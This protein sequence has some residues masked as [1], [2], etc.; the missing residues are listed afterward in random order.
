MGDQIMK[1]FS[2]KNLAMTGALSFAGFGLVGVGAHAVFT[3]STSSQQQIT[4][5]TMNVVLSSSGASGN[6]TAN[7]T[8]ASAG[9]ETS[10]FMTKYDVLIT[11][12]GNI[13][14]HE[15]AYTLSDV[16]TA[17]LES[18]VWACLYSNGPGNQ[19]IYFNEPLTTALSYGESA[20]AWTLAASGGTDQYS[21]VIY[22]GGVDT[23]CGGAYTGW[24]ASP[25]TGPDG[26]VIP[27][28]F[29]S[30][31][32]FVGP[33]PTFGANPAALSLDNSAQGGVITPTMTV[34]FSA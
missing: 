17:A 10:S 15:I 23:G 32:P 29:T 26:I 12:N 8:L 6:G 21:L 31:E 1:F 24:S 27:H 11:N 2:F 22:A 28:S 18:Q 16:G 20:A 33:A 4:A 5:G 9:P 34:N 19:Y 30:G 7:I 13:P 14:V 3:Q 25:Y